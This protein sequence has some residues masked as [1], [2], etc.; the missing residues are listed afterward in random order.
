[1]PIAAPDRAWGRGSGSR[2][3]DEGPVTGE[4]PPRRGGPPAC[5]SGPAV[6]GEDDGNLVYFIPDY[7][8]IAVPSRPPYGLPAC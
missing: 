8:V 2:T 6:T 3:G 7:L 4:A 1:M 5:P